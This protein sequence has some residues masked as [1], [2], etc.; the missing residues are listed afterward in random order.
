MTRVWSACNTASQ[1]DLWA[2]AEAGDGASMFK[3]AL[4]YSLYDTSLPDTITA[5]SSHVR[6]AKATTNSAIAVQTL[7]CRPR[8]AAANTLVERS[9]M[10][11][12]LTLPKLKLDCQY[13][14]N[15]DALEGH[16]SNLFGVNL[17]LQ[18]SQSSCEHAGEKKL[19]G[20]C[21]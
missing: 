14:G 12:P 5:A 15:P 17:A 13:D 3:S 10:E 20:V 19:D 4:L 2:V 8:R 1:P 11:L 21:R 6:S 9:W 18:A 7:L 16:P